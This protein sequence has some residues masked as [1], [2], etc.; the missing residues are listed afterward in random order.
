MYDTVD[1]STNIVKHSASG[2]QKFSFT[3]C[4]LPGAFITGLPEG[5]IEAISLHD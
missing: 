4:L 5:N 2:W 1:P 3:V